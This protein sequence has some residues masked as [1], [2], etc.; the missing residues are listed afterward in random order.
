M[1]HNLF[2]PGMIGKTYVK[3]RIVMAPMADNM[4]NLD[5]SVS[6]QVIAYYSERA[7][8]GAGIIMPG[9]VGL[10]FT[11]E[12]SG[13]GS[14]IQLRI[15]QAGYV[16]GFSKLAKAI[17]R[18]GSLLILQLAHAGA[19]TNPF[20][21]GGLP[22][23]C[24]SDVDD[25]EHIM[26]KMDRMQGAQRE[27]RTEDIPGIIKR[28]VE[29]AVYAKLAGCD[30]VEIHGSHGY[31]I[32]EFLS[33]ETNRR[34]DEYGGSLEDR[35]KFPLAIIQGIRQACG[36]EFL[37]GVR[38]M[39]REWVSNG[40][41][42]EECCQIA[43]AY[44]KAGCD[45]LDVSGGLTPVLSNIEESQYK[46]QGDRIEFIEKIK[47]SVNIPVMA[48][49]AFRDPD[50]C[51]RMLEENKLDYVSLGRQLICDPYWPEKT[52]AGK[53]S[54]IRKCTSCLEGCFGSIFECKPV[55]C[56][57]NPAA[58]NEIAY[59]DV[60][61]S[62]HPQN[63]VVVGG[64]PGG[65]Q[66]AVTAAGLGH[67]VTLLEKSDRLGGQMNLASIPPHKDKINFSTE[68]F[69]GELKRRNVMVI[70]DCDADAG[71]IASLE[72][73]KV[74]VAT[75]AIPFTPPIPGSENGVQ[76]WDI[77]NGTVPLP[78]NKKI[79]I[80]GGG[81]VGCE[82]ASLL[83]TKGNRITILEM[84]P[85]IAT[86]LEGTHK[87][88]LLGEFAAS[89]INA[90]TSATVKSIDSKKV[91]FEVEK[92]EKSLEHDMVILSVGLKSYG[93]EIAEQ[94]ADMGIETIR[95]GD[96]YKPAKIIN[97]VHSGF[98]AALNI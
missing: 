83:A 46:N 87:L 90:I 45:F 3:N 17:H 61:K 68:W 80:I 73:D 71:F 23:V 47:K 40:L 11:A 5:G 32:N 62:E 52:K 53:V 14:P 84:L 39:G 57:Y 72:P 89:G 4:A 6:D 51:E 2:K 7:K 1:H 59:A 50:Y 10:D 44:E 64:G 29:A 70:T 21:T 9:F 42:D 77:L 63:V 98:N 67:R 79:T 58:G 69:A 91:V 19:Q 85:E 95:V 33:P 18:Y 8:G 41:S 43:Q 37:V 35:L 22:P 15:D 49:S 12:T 88:D 20:L 30:G 55:S 86:G 25:I 36:P 65:M 96:V 93:A 48:V 13:R 27:L 81:I 82:T 97:A 75:G 34:T 24:V 74:I 38:T 60:R 28:F 31:L 66:A 16:N 78:E 92:E 76:S 56:T 94:L 26:I 54:E